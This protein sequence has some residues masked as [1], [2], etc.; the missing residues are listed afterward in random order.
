[1]RLTLEEQASFSGTARNEVSMVC[2]ALLDFVREDVR[3]SAELSKNLV[4]ARESRAEL[5]K[6]PGKK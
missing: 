1:M 2:P 3:A 4:K 5:I 6:A